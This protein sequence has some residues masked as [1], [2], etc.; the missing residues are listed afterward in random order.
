MKLDSQTRL[1]SFFL[2]IILISPFLISS[3]NT[4]PAIENTPDYISPSDLMDALN[5]ER[6]FIRELAAV[7][8]GEN[9]SSDAID[10]LVERLKAPEEK[11]YV[12]AA[13]ARALGLIRNSRAAPA[14]E[15]LFLT[16]ADPEVRFQCI[17]ALAQFAAFNPSIVGA[18]EAGL[19][20]EDLLVRSL[21]EAELI[22]IRGEDQ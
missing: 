18:L 15:S 12:K 4:T 10:S 9:R 20:D 19:Q 1:F 21:C 22:K 16:S 7:K 11:N 17:K 13:A 3:C 6:S 14:L 2:G 5:D 8:L